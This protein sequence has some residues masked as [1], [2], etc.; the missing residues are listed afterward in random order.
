MLKQSVTE[1]IYKT[2][3]LSLA[4]SLSNNLLSVQREICQRYGLLP[5][6]EAHLTLAFFGE[7]SARKLIVLAGALLD[8]LPSPAISEIRIDGLGGAC[9]IGGKVSL[10]KD[11]KPDDLKDLPRVLWLAASPHDDLLA[12]REKSLGVARNVGVNTSFNGPNF[13]PHLTLGSAG[14]ADHGNWTL[15]DVHTV[16]KRPTIDFELPM[17]KVKASKLHLT[18]VS[19]NPDS[20]HLLSPFPV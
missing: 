12:F 19:I 11:E 7:T 1:P 2:A 13:Y 3:Y 15:F 17:D 18:D 4:F 20:V 16:A 9:E 6:S 8:I 10:I 5:R 14:P